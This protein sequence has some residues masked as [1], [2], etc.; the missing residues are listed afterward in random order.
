MSKPASSSGA[1]ASYGGFEYQ[2]LATAWLAM[3]LIWE[4]RLCESITVE[5]AS[6]EDVAAVLK[7]PDRSDE[8]ST[9]IGVPAASSRLDIQIKRRATAWTESSIRDV[10]KGDDSPAGSRGPKPRA[11]PLDRLTSDA[12]LRFLLLTNAQVVAGLADFVVGDIGVRSAAIALPIKPAVASAATIAPRIGIISEHSPAQLK[13]E[14]EK[15]LRIHGHVSDANV[16]ACAQNLIAEVRLR[17]LGEAPRLWRRDDIEHLIL[18]NGGALDNSRAIV[19]PLVFPKLQ[20]RL[21]RQHRLLLTGD[22]GVGKTELAHELAQRHHQSPDAFKIVHSSSGI[23]GIRNALASPGPHL[24]LI[25]DPWGHDRLM[26]EAAAWANELPKLFGKAGPT[27]RFV[28]TSRA[29]VRHEAFGNRPIP[30][31]TDTEFVLKPE[32]Y[33]DEQRREIMRIRMLPAQPWQRDW[34][35]RHEKDWM[36][37]LNVPLAIVHFAS[38]V[39]QT[40]AE[41]DLKI[42]EVLRVSNV[43]A[44]SGTFALEIKERGLPMVAGALLLWA[45]HH[46]DEHVTP[47][48]ARAGKTAAQIGNYRGPL[49]PEK[50]LEIFIGAGWFR[51]AKTGYVAH[52]TALTGIESLLVSEPGTA[53][54]VIDALLSGLVQSGEIARAFTIVQWLEHRPSAVSGVVRSKVEEHLLQKFMTDKGYDARRAFDYLAEHS[55]SAKP[56]FRLIRAMKPSRGHGALYG[57]EFWR[58]P[59]ISADQTAEITASTEAREVARNVVTEILPNDSI[60]LYSAGEL[61]PFFQQFGWNFE[62]EFSTAA[63]EALTKYDGHARPHFLV[64]AALLSGASNFA[65]LTDAVLIAGDI[66][67]KLWNNNAEGRRQGDQAEIDADYASHLVEEGSELFSPIERARDLIVAARRRAEGW[68]WLDAHPRRPDLLWAWANS[69]NRGTKPAEF[70][71]LAAACTTSR[72]PLWQALAGPGDQKQLRALLSEARAAPVEEIRDWSDQAVKL[73]TTTEWKTIAMPIIANLPLAHRMTLATIDLRG[74]DHADRLSSLPS[75]LSTEEQ[76][77]RDICVASIKGESWT[78]VVTVAHRAALRELARNGSSYFKRASTIALA[79]LKENIDE[80]TARLRASEE[81]EDRQTALFAILQTRTDTSA[82]ALSA[83]DDPDYR[84]RRL[85]LQIV[86]A[87]PEPGRWPSILRMAADPSAPVRAVCAEIIGREKHIDGVPTLVSLL[88]DRRDR[89]PSSLPNASWRDHHVARQRPRRS[90]HSSLVTRPSR[91]ACRSSRDAAPPSTNRTTSRLT[92]TC[93]L[94]CPTPTTTG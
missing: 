5:P 46:A 32:H 40:T 31:F 45:L 91:P 20:E 72:R 12:D 90:V 11:R 21:D 27:K 86:A 19:L 30:G 10:L 73:A 78:G 7:A 59:T 25:E 89:R 51:P 36:K 37:Q 79:V 81:N 56:A 60:D 70:A 2:F 92:I 85:A 84:V 39:I 4:Q 44:L 87:L 53:D 62:T 23:Q 47:D 3:K 58:P 68:N 6:Q 17:V 9:H 80:F 1:G 24:F 43:E 65:A 61:V 63:A 14:L 34:V 38:R 67:N 82:A 42:D 18:A 71:A 48:S 29:G 57:I 52:P 8:I 64:E 94:L 55:V 26:N 16:G 41:A 15:Y 69:I 66:A 35:K 88:D 74:E 77:V 50:T 76:E 13:L 28:V 93:S 54:E 22:P 83:L 75:I 49:D 33:S